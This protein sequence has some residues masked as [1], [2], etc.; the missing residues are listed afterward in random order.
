MK[1]EMATM[2]PIAL[3][4]VCL[5]LTA[6]VGL[7]KPAMDPTRYDLGNSQATP[8]ITL[9]SNLL[10]AEIS[11]PS[12]LSNRNIQYRLAYLLPERVDFYTQSQWVSEPAE[13]LAHRLNQVV[14][15]ID[16]QALSVHTLTG[17]KLDIQL[18]DFEQVF[19]APETSM[20]LVRL[21]VAVS[22]RANR[23]ILLQ[24]DFA[25]KQH[26]KTSDAQGAVIALTAASGQALHDLAAW[27]A[28]KFDPEKPEGRA[29]LQ[30]C[31]RSN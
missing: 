21:H 15:D 23:L 1:M 30:I 25:A 22:H 8:S 12:W 10:S 18:Q 11:A 20:A 9:P 26:A 13:L 24:A 2:K 19:S 16:T 17:C 3:F 6:C 29:Y 7:N 5:W 14:A 4:T 31:T 28:L 27:L